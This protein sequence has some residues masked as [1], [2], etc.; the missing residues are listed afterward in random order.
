VAKP[1]TEPGGAEPTPRR[2]LTPILLASCS[3]S[4]AAEAQSALAP[5]RPAAWTQPFGRSWIRF[6]CDTCS[7]PDHHISHPPDDTG[8]V[9]FEE[10]L[11]FTDC[12]ALEPTL[13]ELEVEKDDVVALSVGLCAGGSGSAT[14]C[15]PAAA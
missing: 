14:S 8:R 2:T 7:R 3:S 1:G 4:E 10:D 11:Y 5:E 6:E 12:G 15:L 9:H 13:D